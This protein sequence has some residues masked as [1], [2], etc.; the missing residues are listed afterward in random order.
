MANLHVVELRSPHVLKLECSKVAAPIV[1]PYL[2][3][4]TSVSLCYHDK[5]AAAGNGV[6]CLPLPQCPQAA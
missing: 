4:L 1:S 5:A 3:I 6:I 2:G